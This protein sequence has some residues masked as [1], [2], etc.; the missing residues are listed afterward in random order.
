MLLCPAVYFL[1]C[2]LEVEKVHATSVPF[3]WSVD[4]ISFFLI[5][6]LWDYLNT[7][8]EYIHQQPPASGENWEEDTSG[9][10]ASHGS[11]QTPRTAPGA[12]ADNHDMFWL[13]YEPDINDMDFL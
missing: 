13:N 5:G 9:G 11:D 10:T 2:F 7:R 6:R 1:F 8:E 12:T 3:S 4:D